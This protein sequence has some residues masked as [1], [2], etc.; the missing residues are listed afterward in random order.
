MVVDGPSP[1]RRAKAQILIARSA[2]VSEAE[3]ADESGG[4]VAPTDIAELSGAR[5]ML[6]RGDGRLVFHLGTPSEG[7]YALWLR[8]RWEPESSTAMTLVLND[9]EVRYLRATAM[10]GF[11][12]WTN[13]SRAHTKMFAHFGEQY[14]HWAWYRIPDVTL[15]ASTHRLTIGA[16]AG[17]C[18]DA[19]L[20]L[21]Q[22]PA[23]DRAAMNLMQ[24][25]NYRP[26]NNP[27]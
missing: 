25:W 13:P 7:K 27:L 23:V 17:A 20:L 21:P 12:D 6:F 5:G 9:G 22:N 19:V 16:G 4:D 2:L 1:P 26:W 18:F 10:I 15:T 24:N 14:G 11:T 3:Y 8:A